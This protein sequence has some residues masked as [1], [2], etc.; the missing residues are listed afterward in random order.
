MATSTATSNTT[1]TTTAATTAEICEDTILTCLSK[2]HNR[3]DDDDDDADAGI[4]D[5]YPWSL[6]NSFDPLLVI[7][8]VNSL[9]TEGYVVTSDVSTSFYTLTA[10]GEH[11]L[12]HGSQEMMVLN[13]IVAAA[14]NQSL[15][16][17]E[18]ESLVGKDIAKIGLGNCLKNK[19]ISK[20]GTSYIPVVAA[21]SSSVH[22]RI[23]ATQKSLQDLSAGNFTKDAID[24]KVCCLE[25]ID[26]DIFSS[27][28]V[29]S[30][31]SFFLSPWRPFELVF[32]LPFPDWYI[33]EEA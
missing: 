26:G 6:Q 7:G 29:S 22:D 16:L 19:W 13:A 1:I 32:F 12:Q 3:D 15:S 20:D 30:R 17:E 14:P 27:L 28:S 5:T 24:D 9:S 10:E 31:L 4:E 21:S 8:V 33:A 18:I 2:N 23:D 25:G 11:I